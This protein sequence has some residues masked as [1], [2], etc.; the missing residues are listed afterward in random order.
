VHLSCSGCKFA[1]SWSSAVAAA[2][3]AAANDS[4]NGSSDEGLSHAAL[5]CS[6]LA[7]VAEPNTVVALLSISRAVYM[8]VRISHSTLDQQQQLH[9]LICRTQTS[10]CRQLQAAVLCTQLIIRLEGIRLGMRK[11]PACTP[12]VRLSRLPSKPHFNERVTCD[13]SR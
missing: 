1:L 7:A 13:C 12:P 8:E 4:H 3:S 10:A 6:C 9:R 2:A 11:H 5:P